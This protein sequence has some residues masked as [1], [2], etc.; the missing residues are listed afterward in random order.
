M[1]RSVK[2]VTLAS[3]DTTSAQLVTSRELVACTEWLSA[4]R[5]KSWLLDREQNGLSR[6]VVKPSERLVLIDLNE[7]ER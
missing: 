6:A 5:L 4:R 7:W 2:A 1:D 3:A